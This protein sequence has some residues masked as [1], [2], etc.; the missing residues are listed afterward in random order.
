MGVRQGDFNI[1]S[2]ASEAFDERYHP[3]FMSEWAKDW[4]AGIGTAQGANGLVQRDR[5]VRA[6]L[7]HRLTTRRPNPVGGDKWYYSFC[8]GLWMMEWDTWHCTYVPFPSF[9]SPFFLSPSVWPRTPHS[10]VLYAQS[11]T[12]SSLQALPRMRASRNLALPALQQM[13]LV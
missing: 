10:R 1:P 3:D 7:R 9:P 6:L 5:H 4:N 11:L 8:R 2:D 13:Y 12:E